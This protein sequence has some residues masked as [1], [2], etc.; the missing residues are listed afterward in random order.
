MTLLG[1]VL[2][3]LFAFLWLSQELRVA[4]LKKDLEIAHT[5]LM[6]DDSDV[7]PLLEFKVL[8]G[9]PIFPAALHRLGMKLPAER[10]G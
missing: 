9:E 6:G 7:R 8:Q 10:Q 4:E 1:F 2:A 3:A 5:I